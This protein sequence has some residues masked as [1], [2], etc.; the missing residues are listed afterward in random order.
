MEVPKMKIR[1]AYQWDRTLLFGNLNHIIDS[2][3]DYLE[4]STFWLLGAF[5]LLYLLWTSL[6]A[7]QKPMWND[8]LYTYYIA[9][10]PKTS[11]IWGALMSGAEQ[12]PPFFHLTTRAA[13]YLFGVNHVAVRLPAV[14]GF[15]I[16]LLCLFRFVAKRSSPVYGLVAM[17]FPL[18]TGAYTY[19]Y[20]GRPYGIVLGFSGL[21]LVCWQSATEGLH[22]RLA[23]V[24]LALSLAGALANHYYAILVFF[25]IGVGELVRSLLVRRLDLPIWGAFF[26]AAIVPLLLFLPLITQSRDYSVT[27][28]NK[29]YPSQVPNFYY[30]LLRPAALP[31]VAALFV[32]AVYGMTQPIRQLTRFDHLPRRTLPLHELA[33]AFGF[34]CIPIVGYLVARFI[35][36]A[37]VDRYF[38]P[39]VL[40]FSVL[41]AF[42]LYS[43]P[44]GRALIGTTLILFL[45]SWFIVMQLHA[46]GK[47]RQAAND[48]QEMVQL[49]RTEADNNLPIVASEPHIFMQL[50]YY[51][52]V[53]VSSRL[54]YL[55]DPDL[56]LRHLG[57][58]SVDRGMQDLI[59]PWFHLRVEEYRPYIA[60]HRQFLVYGN[61]E[62]LEW[63]V[64]QLRSDNMRIE[65]KGKHG[66]DFLLLVSSTE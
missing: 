52:P 19:A 11:D 23:L 1:P 26:V 38:L 60:S 39:A 8:E 30:S 48:L 46:F 56:S 3:Q 50:A 9:T 32:T 28:W 7:A 44:R 14:I 5:S 59:K 64:D 61:L 27:F 51:A 25:A 65:L 42:A 16:M 20:E 36:R 57:H 18:I 33:A 22:R 2:V 63:L 62:W 29:V 21:A 12:I 13:F 66:R 43:L 37:F 53:D 45:C 4:K 35:T 54:V 34:I 47:N 55:A 40:G 10:L 17:L 58:N 41:V 31:L 49:L 15:L 6:L 24:C